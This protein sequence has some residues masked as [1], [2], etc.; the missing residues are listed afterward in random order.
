MNQC[1]RCENFN[2][3]LNICTVK[4]TFHKPSDTGKT[5]CI[6]HYKE[7]KPSEE[8]EVQDGKID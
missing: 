4:G 3:S 7:G 2:K 1:G 6:S 8:E 5:A